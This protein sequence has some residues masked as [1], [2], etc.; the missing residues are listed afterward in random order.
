M[1]YDWKK[2]FFWPTRRDLRSEH[3]KDKR[4]NIWST[5]SAT[6]RKHPAKLI[7]G[8]DCRAAWN[9]TPSPKVASLD[10]PRGFYGKMEF[11]DLLGKHMDEFDLDCTRTFNADNISTSIVQ[12]IRKHFILPLNR[13][14]CTTQ[15]ELLLHTALT[16]QIVWHDPLQGPREG[17]HQYHA[18][19][20]PKER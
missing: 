2:H 12:N 20:E 19:L 14:R 3:W 6:N 8:M 7:L 18:K 15:S 4:Q 10:R 9:F 5:V 13:Q 17:V 11:F 16:G 1:F